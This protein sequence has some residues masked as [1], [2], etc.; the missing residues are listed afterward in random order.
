M[1]EIALFGNP[2]KRRRRTKAKAKRA[3]TRTRTR[4]RKMKVRRA[5]ASRPRRR[6]RRYLKNISISGMPNPRSRK[7]RYRLRGYRRNPTGPMG[8]VTQNLVPASI[9]AGGALGLDV[10]LGFATPFLPAMLTTGPMRPVLRIAGAIGLGMLATQVSGRKIGEQVAAGAITVTVYD[11]LKGLVKQFAP[12]LALGENDYPVLGYYS[13]GIQVGND[14]M[15][16]YGDYG[17]GE[18]VDGMGQYVN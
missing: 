13:P 1:S 9:G 8:F 6:K 16:A 15:G 18:Y 17:V 5:V 7:K 3:R 10:L 11:I 2:R 12:T 4:A 14:N